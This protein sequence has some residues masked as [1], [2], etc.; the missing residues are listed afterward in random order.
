[1]H[2][3]QKLHVHKINNGLELV[4]FKTQFPLGAFTSLQ[5]DWSFYAHIKN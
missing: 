5:P 2:Y 4:L 1:M 3:E